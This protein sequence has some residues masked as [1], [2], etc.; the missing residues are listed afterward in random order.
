V[1]RGGTAVDE[2]LVLLH[3]GELGGG[4]GVDDL[5]N[6]VPVL[7]GHLVH[8]LDLVH[9]TQ[10]APLDAA[11]YV[12]GITRQLHLAALRRRTPRA[13]S[14]HATIDAPRW[15]SAPYRTEETTYT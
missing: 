4:Q 3:G 12:G 14:V 1:L 10:V 15:S 9:A 2:G 7:R 6:G 8:G 5:E 13:G 11:R